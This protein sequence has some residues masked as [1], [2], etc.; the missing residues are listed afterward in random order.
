M[1]DSSC[2]FVTNH[3]KIMFAADIPSRL[4][5]SKNTG[6]AN[7]VNCYIFFGTKYL[8]GEIIKNQEVSEQYDVISVKTRL[9]VSKKKEG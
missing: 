8:R 9:S 2:D 6:F 4:F 5:Y 7:S 3:K 1:L